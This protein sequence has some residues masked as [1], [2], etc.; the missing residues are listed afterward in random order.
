MRLQLRITAAA[1]AAT[2]ALSSVTAY[3]DWIGDFYN[4]AGAAVNTTAPQ[5][6]ASQSVVGYSGGGLSWRVPNKNFQPLMIT[7]PS[8][9][10]GCGG[11]DVYLGGFSF[12][13]KAEFVQAL[14]NFG[15]A[16]LGY[17]FELAL[18]TMA[19]EIAVTLDVINDLANRINQFS[20]NSCRAAQKAV[21]YLAGDWMEANARDATGYARAAGEFVDE[22]DAMFGIQGNGQKIMQEKYMQNYGKPRSAVI[23]ADNGKA[24]PVYVNL[25]RWALDH[26]NAVNL[27]DD[28]KDL[29][30]SIV[31]PTVIVT[32]GT[33]SDGNE[34]PDFNAGRPGTIDFSH[35]VGDD[36]LTASVLQPLKVLTCID[37]ECTTVTDTTKTFMPFS[38]RAM[39]AVTHIRQNIVN[40]T[41]GNTL[42][43]DE[44]LVLK[45]SSVPLY[46]AAA[47]AESS[48]VAA[49]VADQLV[50]DLVDYAAVDAAFNM[51]TYYLNTAD[52]A[53][54]GI[55][56]KVPQILMAPYQEMRERIKAIR[57]DMHQKIT[58]FYQ[59]KGNPYEKID[60]LDKV[61]RAM[62]A[63]LNTML[64][65]NARFGKRQ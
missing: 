23:A 27:N 8:L 7:P 22:F 30:M 3:A 65:A 2:L 63:N 38:A 34:A 50:Y 5:A 17:F 4:S 29:I 28:E 32:Q 53:L 24:I 20:M 59:Q 49:I 61:E 13:N 47:M 55:S 37:A 42:T 18:R 52:K 1:V 31:G 33:D 25:L 6:I 11:I 57:V 56:A 62:Y 26:N 41:S 48:G 45:M 10:A 35:L 16:A 14:R 15:Q 58:H 19:P 39:G 36:A 51:M 44:L 46:R 60:Q 43:P 64:A 12:P 21:N 9:K 54:N 40:R